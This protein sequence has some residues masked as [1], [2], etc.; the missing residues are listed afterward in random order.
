MFII[1]L[2]LASS[3]TLAFEHPLEDPNSET[4]EI[5]NKIDIF[6][7]AFFCLEAVLKIVSFGFLLNGKQ[8]YLRDAWNILDFIIVVFSV[9][10]ILIYS[11]LSVVKVLRVARILRPLRLI[12]R[13]EGLKIAT[14][15]FFKA[16]PQILRLHI[17]I[18]FMMFMVSIL[19]TT[20][21]SGK[22]YSCN[23]G[24]TPLAYSQ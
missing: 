13:A 10:G 12:Q 21:L 22:L 19:M 6:F 7:T 1:L 4:M 5:L 16:L 20:L 3:L 15:A 9:L 17:V 24:H 23:L 18:S 8:S 11:D 2:I 14:M